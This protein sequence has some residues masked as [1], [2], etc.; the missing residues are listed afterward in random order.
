MILVPLLYIFYALF[1]ELYGKGH[2][3][4]QHFVW[5][6]PPQ[7]GIR[8]EA[9]KCHTHRKQLNGGGPEQTKISRLSFLSG[10]DGNP[11]PILMA[12]VCDGS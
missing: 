9:E 7:T 2:I 1:K 8:E 11:P 3:G 5:R 12:M 4:A 10:W 6:C